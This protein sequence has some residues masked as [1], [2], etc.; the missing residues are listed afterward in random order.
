[1]KAHLFLVLLLL[2]ATAFSQKTS[3]WI[4]G[5]PGRENAWEEP[6]NWHNGHVPDAFSYVVIEAKNSGHHAMPILGTSTSVAQVVLRNGAELKI[7]PSG[8][9]EIDGTDTYSYG[10]VLHGGKVF[11]EGNVTLYNTKSP[12]RIVHG[13][14][15]GSL[16]D[17]VDVA[18]SF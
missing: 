11:N 1:M 13:K 18:V 10:I 17:K 15:P 5:T 2:T 8:S 4:G 9:L 14:H 3:E 7:T 6:R 16:S 12:A